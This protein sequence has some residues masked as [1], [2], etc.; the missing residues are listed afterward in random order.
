MREIPL[1]WRFVWDQMMDMTYGRTL[2]RLVVLA[3]LWSSQSFGGVESVYVLKEID[4]DHIIIV[5]QGGERLL[6]KKWTLRL[7]PLLFEGN[8]FTAEVSASWITIHFDDRDPI[9]WSAEKSLGSV[10]P[11]SPMHHQEHPRKHLEPRQLSRA[12]D[13]MNPRFKVQLRFWGTETR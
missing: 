6:L 7:S 5:T 3:I 9:K 10:S 11:K 4:N 1:I 12:A 13:V 2:I 8:H